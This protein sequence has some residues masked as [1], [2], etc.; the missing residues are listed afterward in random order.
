MM[1]G[2]VIN[3]HVHGALVRL[4]DGSLAAVG[5]AELA[6]HRAVYASSLDRRAPLDLV[7]DRSGRH[8]VASLHE[9]AE[10]ERERE[11]AGA[12]AALGAD[13]AFEARIGAYLKETEAWAPPDRPA[14][15]ERH[16]IRKKRRAALFEARNTAT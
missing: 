7:V 16:F 12:D 6:A 8:P 2:T 15:A 4:E 5:Q 1:R 14:P 3:I 9:R 13:P 10:A 11:R